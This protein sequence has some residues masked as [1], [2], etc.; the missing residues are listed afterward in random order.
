LQRWMSGE[1]VLARPSTL[2]YRLRMFVARHRLE[3]AALVVA[4]VALLGGL[5]AAIVQAR[6][7]EAEASRA[8]AVTRFLTTMLGSADPNALGRDVTVREVVNKATADAEAL[9]ATPRL[10]SAVRGVIGQ[11]LAGLGDFDAAAHQYAVAIEA[12]RR[13]AP[14]GSAETVRLLTMASFAHEN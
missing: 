13:V 1:P 3:A 10:A 14:A 7:A 6:R 8:T 5:L 2:A 11:T 9:D 12:E 4:I